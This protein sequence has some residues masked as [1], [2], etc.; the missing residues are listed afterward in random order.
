[1]QNKRTV[2]GA[3][4]EHRKEIY[5][6]LFLSLAVFIALSL[7][8]YDSFD[9]SFSTF[10]VGRKVHNMGGIVGSYLADLFL[11]LFGLVAWLLPVAG[12]AI[13]FTHF[14]Q[15]GLE[16]LR[17]GWKRTLAYLGAILLATVFMHLK[18]GEVE[19]G[20]KALDA[21]GVFG[22]WLGRTLSR[23]FGRTGAY[24]LVSSGL[25]LAF[26]AITRVS[27]LRLVIL[28]KK[29]AAA[30]LGR[31]RS[32]A[33]SFLVVAWARLKRGF[34]GSLQQIRA[35]W[36]ERRKKP[37][38]V[39]HLVKPVP[40]P[41]L[42]P[43]TEASRK[44]APPP[45]EP[46]VSPVLSEEGGPKILPR[47][48]LK[49]EKRSEQLQ[50]VPPTVADYVLPQISFL[51][52]ESQETTQVDEDTLKLNSKLLEKK[53]TD[54]GV[55]GR[56]TAIHPGPI[57]TMYEF[58]PAAGVKVNK[59]VNLEDD[60]AL[61]MGGKSV[62][63][64]APLPGK[65]AV[66]IEIPNNNRETVWLKDVVGHPKFQK[67]E[68]KL[69]LALGKDTEGIPF[70]ADLAK[71]PHLLVAG[72]TGSGKSV[73]VNSMILSLLYK[74]TPE[75][76]RLIL[77]DLKMLELSIYEG[78]PHLLLPVV[79]APKKASLALRWVV[80]EM[81]RRYET[82]S[83]KAVRNIIGYNKAVPKE[84]RLP[85]IVVIIDELADLMMT[86]SKDVEVSITRLAQMARAAG[87][88]LIL[89]TQRPS[90]DVITGLIKANFPARISFKV[91][92]K[93]DSR[94]IIDTVGS[95]HL[96]GSGDMLFMSGGTSN[97]LRVHGAFVSETEILRVV[98]HWK[99]QGEPKY[100]DEAVVFKPMEEEAEKGGP[101]EDFSDELYD[102]AISI[103]AETRQAS[104]S[105][106][107]RRLRIGYNRA[108]RMIER[109][110]KEGV[111]GP[112]DGARPREVFVNGL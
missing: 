93:H 31:F 71:M 18:M 21:G 99:K 105:M 16:G 89:A 107:Q 32:L 72:A 111:V 100:L 45:P 108:A 104:I 61:T 95:E 22:W 78:I 44:P 62:R 23:F 37:A 8:S 85:Y 3:S 70:V 97:L 83:Q 13:A 25:L 87:I 40:P 42:R 75:E 39:I 34:T 54:Y 4:R 47:M 66:G 74:G 64:I 33:T 28:L 57:I 109:M 15:R 43:A 112:A 48:D 91:T 14:A 7:L 82:L 55:E 110:E 41:R 63:I 90:V 88:H 56:I 24:L 11:T 10:A 80:S 12:L 58:E 94:T 35:W 96:L 53:L 92:S 68:S 9:P 69:T 50:L 102:Q 65:A 84:E 59:I 2:P 17:F 6:L 20:G 73:Q 38:P 52:S 101:E 86:A 106:I 77:V 5:G 29:L 98:D 19:F 30:L 103:V 1:M 26:M 79:T 36:K 27:I 46:V 76:I 49:E 51:D 60:L 81:E 67:M